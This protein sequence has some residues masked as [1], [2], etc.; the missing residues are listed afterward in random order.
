M[1]L[2]IGLP[3]SPETPPMTDPSANPTGPNLFT[4]VAMKF[5]DDLDRF[6]LDATAALGVNG[7]TGDYVEFGSWGGKSLAAAHRTL[8]AGGRTRALWAFDSFEGLPVARDDRDVHPQWGEGG[9]GNSFFGPDAD[10][11][12]LA[13]L[14]AFRVSMLEKGVPRDAYRA[15]PG[16]F[17]DSLPALGDDGPT[18]IA[19]AYVD[20]NMYSSTVTVLE[21]LRPRLKHGMIVAFD[22]FECWTPDQVSGQR[23]A[24]TELLRA[25]PRWR[26]RRYKDIH[27]GGVAFVVEHADAVP[28]EP[29]LSL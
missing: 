6:F 7:I 21:Y 24:L 20:C 28:D 4:A 3:P 1:L 12:G 13:G 5:V 23:L 9:Q 2:T 10:Q 29:R 22:D 18:D 11:A 17:E 27:W 25:E 8:A 16:Y 14:E 26:F 19:M 15:V